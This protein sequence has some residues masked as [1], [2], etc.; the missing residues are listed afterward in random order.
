MRGSSLTQRP[1]SGPPLLLTAC[2]LLFTSLPETVT[3]NNVSLYADDTLLYYSEVNSHENKRCFQMNVDALHEWS[4]R[5]K[6]PFNIE[7]YEVIIFGN[8]SLT[9]PEYTLGG[10]IPLNAFNRPDT[11]V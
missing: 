9:D 10:G 7:K 5:W 2:L 4:N 11:S 3:S 8:G 1:F 6:M